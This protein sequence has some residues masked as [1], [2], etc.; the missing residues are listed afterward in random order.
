MQ[1]ICHRRQ[2][3]CAVTNNRCRDCDGLNVEGVVATQTS[4]G[5]LLDIGVV[6]RQAST[7]DTR[8]RNDEGVIQHRAK[9]IHLVI[10]SAAINVDR[11]IHTV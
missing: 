10:P 1:E 6:N 3:N 5:H 8:S 7:R 4:N 11:R 9:D 2:Y